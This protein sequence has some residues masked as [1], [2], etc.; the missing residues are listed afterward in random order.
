MIK[1]VFRVPVFRYSLIV[2]LISCLCGLTFYFS[3]QYNRA[4]KL[5]EDVDRL[6]TIRENSA[7]IDSCILTL[8]S[9][10]NDSRLYSVT[11]NIQY[12]KQFVKQVKEVDSIFDLIIADSF[13]NS[14][15][16]EK[17]SHLL[18]SK[19]AKTNDYLRL[20]RLSDSLIA[21]LILN[22]I[23]LN[24]DRALNNPD[25]S[26]QEPLR[27]D[28]AAEPK[29]KKLLGR[30][31]DAFSR[32]KPAKAGQITTPQAESAKTDTIYIAG[33]TA[34]RYNSNNRK[35]IAANTGMR[36]KE[37]EMLFV[38]SG[39]IQEL[40]VVLK[41]YKNEE[42]NYVALNKKEL[43]STLHKV[44][45]GFSELSLLTGTILV[46]LL[47]TLL[48]NLWKVFR[49]QRRMVKHGAEA[50]RV[51]TEKSTFLANMSHEIRTP[52]N[53]I[54]GFAEQLEQSQLNTQQSGQI[55]AVRSSA[56]ML[57]SVVNQVL[58]FSKY[59]TGKMNFDQ[60][61]FRLNNVVT[62]V[63][64]AM[65]VLAEQKQLT[66]TTELLYDEEICLS[67]DAFRLRQVLMNLIGNAIKFTNSGKVALKV[68]T[69]L[70]DDYTHKLHVVVEDTGI[71][72]NPTQL[73]FIFKEF[74][75]AGS[76]Q[77][78]N[79]S[80]TGLGLA[81]SKSIV[82]LQGGEITAQSEAGKGSVF[83][84]TIPFQLGENVALKNETEFN[85]EEIRAF[86]KNKR[87]LLAEDNSINVLLAKTILHKWDINCEVA[88]NGKEALSLFEKNTYD[89]VLT[90]I[91]M[92]EMGGVELASRIRQTTDQ[93]KA[94]I[95]IL[96]I[97][98]NVTK[99]DHVY[100]L[101]N[102]INEIA[103]KPFF[104]KELIDKIGSVLKSFIN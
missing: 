53:S 62:E 30:I 94:K 22:P 87:I 20:R 1:T 86:L 63:R 99:E 103:L 23:P 68:W 25:R 78:Q 70:I 16:S 55:K 13:S 96:A 92:P 21:S 79:R 75:Q 58:D 34:N 31:A 61:S 73:P 93:E 42:Q 19:R 52:L 56:D 48:Y 74:T 76:N 83:A 77:K 65:N 10:D 98:A 5:R 95:P 29:R 37:R 69:T 72:I 15:T 100:Y 57:L 59:E 26:F 85:E 40:I 38:N 44:F 49:H 66:L 47:V 60:D 101:G 104:E 35:L 80:G 3:I 2:L 12:L 32:S 43:R 28:T 46:L 7:Q 51:A 88:Y 41:R 54:V 24:K 11:G 9:A 18:E 89:L 71:G 33:G 17:I 67:G 50:S 39:I 102:G 6:V 97:T 36:N 82:E 14:P 84:F 90:D 91:Q 45:S 8:Y 64:R 27:N 81:I 4:Q